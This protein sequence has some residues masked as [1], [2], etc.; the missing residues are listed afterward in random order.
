MP[1]CDHKKMKTI[2]FALALTFALA[3]ALRAADV[4]NTP[5]F[6][7]AV[8]ATNAPAKTLPDL[9]K[10]R[11]RIA[12]TNA[13]PVVGGASVPASLQGATPGAAS[14]AGRAWF[15]PRRD[16]I[17]ITNGIVWAVP[18]GAAWVDVA[19]PTELKLA[20]F[21][22]GAVLT[23]AIRNP[24]NHPVWIAFNPTNTFLL[25]DQLGNAP[26]GR[27]LL[28]VQNVRGEVWVTK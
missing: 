28:H 10:A 18:T 7:P 24:A 12:R 25:T 6:F 15:P 23:L 4:T 3:L 8:E 9:V 14:P 27:Y 19:A 16:Y 13:P 26:A 11:R 21:P 1:T 22:E 5:A 2:L 17:T 20:E